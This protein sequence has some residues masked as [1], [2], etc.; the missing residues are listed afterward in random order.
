MPL[1]SAVPQYFHRPLP[2]PGLEKVAKAD[3]FSLHAGVSCE[4]HRKDKRERIFRYIARPPVAVP[5][6][7]LSPTGKVVYNL[8]KPYRD[9]TT[10]V[11]L[12]PVDFFARLAA[13]VPK[14]RLNHDR[15]H[16]VH[17]NATEHPT[18]HWTA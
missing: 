1:R 2:D 18:A 4:G 16:L 15:R 5:R 17:F 13:L 3:G 12:D 10:Q 7:S 11:V 6:L 9:G 8:K 14:P